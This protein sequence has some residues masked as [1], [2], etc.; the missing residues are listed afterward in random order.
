M[1]D[2]F[3]IV[4]IE[5]G[6]KGVRDSQCRIVHSQ[7]SFQ[8]LAALM[9]FFQPAKRCGSAAIVAPKIDQALLTFEHCGGGDASL[10]SPTGGHICPV[11]TSRQADLER[12]GGVTV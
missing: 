8:G 2:G 5:L 10:T 4:G 1:L 11:S 9:N 6:E 7:I 3:E 12:A